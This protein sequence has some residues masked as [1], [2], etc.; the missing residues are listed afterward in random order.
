MPTNGEPEWQV[1]VVSDE[2]SRNQ[3]TCFTSGRL[4]SDVQS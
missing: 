3:L 1:A 2:L 4:R